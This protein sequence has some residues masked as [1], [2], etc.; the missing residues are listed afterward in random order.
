MGVSI[1]IRERRRQVNLPDV[2]KD[3][4]I[5]LQ[6]KTRLNFEDKTKGGKD[7]SKSQLSFD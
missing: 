4:R 5:T 1:L 6:K 3:I 2:F 7:G